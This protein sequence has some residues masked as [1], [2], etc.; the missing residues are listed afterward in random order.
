MT[1]EAQLNR[2]ARGPDRPAAERAQ[3]QAPT[4]GAC[5][6]SILFAG[7]R[8][9]VLLGA[10]RAAD[11]LVIA[12]TAVL[13]FRYRHGT[14]D[15][16]T[17]YLW[18]VLAVCVMAAQGLHVAGVYILSGFRRHCTR[19][20]AVWTGCMLAVLA[21]IFFEKAGNDI[22]RSWLVLWAV[23]SLGGLLALHAAYWFGLARPHQNKLASHVAV[24]GPRGA[25]ERLARR[26]TETFKRRRHCLRGVRPP[27]E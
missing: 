7:D 13:S 20:A 17:L 27:R 21:I 5:A 24:V 3:A 14:F 15:M 16:P 11:L 2:L 26:I 8:R 10:L 19:I 12:A 1:A 9:A 18:Q 4:S 6:G 22:S 23:A 25:A